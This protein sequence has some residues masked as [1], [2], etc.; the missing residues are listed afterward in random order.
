[1]AVAYVF[2]YNV[3]YTDAFQIL[4]LSYL[5]TRLFKMQSIVVGQI[6][7]YLNNP[8]VRGCNLTLLP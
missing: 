4:T 1:M 3:Q 8:V 5:S 6:P 7:Y 2:K